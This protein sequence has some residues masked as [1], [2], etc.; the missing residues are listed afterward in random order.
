VSESDDRA[1]TGVPQGMSVQ[2]R[3]PRRS[4][5]RRWSFIAAAA[6]LAIL[7]FYSGRITNGFR[8]L[9][10]LAATLPGDESGFN[11]QLNARV[12]QDFPLGSREKK[13]I[14]ELSR[15]GF[16]PEWRERDDANAASFVWTGLLCSKIVRVIWRADEQGLLTQIV[17]SYASKCALW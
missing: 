5:L 16:T 10:E 8:H 7:S 17:G 11:G 14:D 6:A 2:Q 13:L 1:A 3:A 15:Q 4:R 12:Q 9:P